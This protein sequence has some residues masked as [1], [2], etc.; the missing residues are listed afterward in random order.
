[1]SATKGQKAKPSK[2]EPVEINSKS[3]MEVKESFQPP[4]EQSSQDNK[5]NVTVTQEE[6]KKRQQEEEDEAKK[7]LEKRSLRVANLNASQN[8]PTAA[9]MKTLDSSVKRN[10]AVI[11]KLKQITEDQKDSLLSELNQV[12][13]SKY[14]SEA[15]SGIAEAKLKI[16]D[17]YPFT[18]MSWPII[19]QIHCCQSMLIASSTLLRLH[20]AVDPH[21]DQTVCSQ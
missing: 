7:V 3:T 12:N 9:F 5:G 17:V 18:C 11:K 16:S 8:R 15:V 19:P 13:L 20:A 14:I 6:E 2:E 21:V 10:T 4:T 1:M